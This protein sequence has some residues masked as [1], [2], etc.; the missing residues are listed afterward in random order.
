LRQEGGKG[1]AND[2]AAP[3]SRVQGG[4]KLGDKTNTYNKYLFS[5]LKKN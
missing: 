1:R 2:A 5:T 4:G 3:G